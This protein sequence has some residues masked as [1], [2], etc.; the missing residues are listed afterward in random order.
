[1]AE[2]VEDFRTRYRHVQKQTGTGAGGD[3]F[4]QAWE[5]KD[6]CITCRLGHDQNGQKL[7]I[8]PDDCTLGPQSRWQTS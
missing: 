3:R 4:S 7:L 8:G 1:M 5:G 2:K 6:Y